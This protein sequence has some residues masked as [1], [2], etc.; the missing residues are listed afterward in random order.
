VPAHYALATNYVQMDS[1]R[2]ARRTYA[3]MIRLAAG[4]EDEHRVALAQAYRYTSVMDLVEK[5]WSA[6]LPGL[7][8]ALRYDPK[9]VELRLYR[10]QALFALNR[11]AEARREFETVLQLQPDNADAKH[12]LSLLAQYN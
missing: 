7:D 3:T 4:H 5:D 11:K 6:A 2:A 8:Q 1:T 9:D 12:G 10:A